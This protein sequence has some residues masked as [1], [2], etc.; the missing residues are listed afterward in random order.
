MLPDRLAADAPVVRRR[1]G[2]TECAAGPRQLHIRAG[3]GG[4]GAVPRLERDVAHRGHL[5]AGAI[6]RQSR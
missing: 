5:D 6:R 2:D 1:I 4:P 3:E